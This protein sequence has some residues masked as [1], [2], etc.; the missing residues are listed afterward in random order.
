MAPLTLP[1]ICLCLH[2]SSPFFKRDPFFLHSFHPSFFQ[3]CGWTHVLFCTR[4]VV[5]GHGGDWATLWPSRQWGQ[6]ECTEAWTAAEGWKA[7]QK[8][9]G[10]GSRYMEDVTLWR[11][12]RQH[13]CDRI[14]GGTSL[15]SPSFSLFYS[16]FL[17]FWR[18]LSLACCFMVNMLLVHFFYLSIFLEVLFQV[19]L[20]RRRTCSCGHLPAYSEPFCS[21]CWCFCF[22]HSAWRQPVVLQCMWWGMA[23]LLQYCVP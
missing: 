19:T 4:M 13:C 22:F 12:S 14:T 17:M 7:L 15:I 18:C 9:A 21:C 6:W 2:P 11:L 10:M 16:S 1:P 23:V 3:P 5:S 20:Y 8:K